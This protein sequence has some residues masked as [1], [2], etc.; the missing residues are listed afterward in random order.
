MTSKQL[1]NQIRNLL[2]MLLES[3]V[4]IAANSVAEERARHRTRVTWR[5]PAKATG[6]LSASVFATV[7][8]Y[9]DLLDTQAYSAVLYDGALLQI[10][11][12]FIGHLL[13]GHRLCFYPCPFEV[14]SQLL[15]SDPM[16][17][18]I[19]M[20]RE[21]S[22]TK[23]YLRSPCRFDFDNQN[24]GSGHPSVHLHFNKAD[25]RWPV[26]RPLSIGEFLAFVFRHFYPSLWAVQPF[27]RQWPRERA[28]NR[29]T[30]AT[31]EADLHVAC[32]TS[33]SVGARQ[34]T[35]LSR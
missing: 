12:D 10:S 7:S 34:L 35:M 31:E 15:R 9:C 11:Y 13:V 14:D 6:L 16:G 28:G 30:T 27:L 3:E 4:A 1:A 25:C 33:L 5:S 24:Q 22:E 17:D 26:T 18:V 32:G 2:R 8:E 23:R 20:Y 19:A 29:M 21:S